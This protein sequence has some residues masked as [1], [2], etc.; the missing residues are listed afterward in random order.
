MEEYYIGER[1]VG[2]AVS[3]DGARDN[4]KKCMRHRPDQANEGWSGFHSAKSRLVD[5]LKEE[6]AESL[7]NLRFV[8]FNCIK[9][10]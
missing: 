6:E 9:G 1:R 2:Q 7:K 5:L 8:F 10:T 3:K 4:F